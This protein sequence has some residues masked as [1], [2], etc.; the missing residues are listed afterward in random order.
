MDVCCQVKDRLQALTLA[1][2]LFSLRFGRTDLRSRD[3]KTSRMDSLPNF[4]RCGPG[5]AKKMGLR[6]SFVCLWKI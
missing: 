2:A 6:Q 4:L 1:F 3:T 5:S